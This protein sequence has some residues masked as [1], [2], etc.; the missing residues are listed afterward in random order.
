MTLDD[1]IDLIIH[2]VKNSKTGEIW[3]PKLKSMSI[4]DLA[5]IFSERYRKPIK[6]I[7]MRPGEKIHEEMITAADS[8]NTYDLGK[9]YVILPTKVS[10]DLDKYMEANNG[11]K[12][13][14]G[15]RYNSGE[16]S[17][18]ETVDSLREKIKDFIDP[19]FS[20]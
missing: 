1:S 4:L 3:L 12:V 5:E 6:I 9:Y 19:D 10:W 16:N 14:E 7:G 8:L 2:T 17:D 20:F 15:F 18:W 11:Q 13:P